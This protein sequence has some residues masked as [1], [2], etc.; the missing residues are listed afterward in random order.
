MIVAVVT[1]ESVAI[2]FASSA[3]DRRL[4]CAKG[5]IATKFA[6]CASGGL[7]CRAG[8]SA[9]GRVQQRRDRRRLRSSR[10][11][12]SRRARSTDAGRRWRS[13]AGALAERARPRSVEEIDVMRA[14]PLAA[15][16]N[17]RAHDAR[18]PRHHHDSGG[19]NIGSRPRFGMR[20]HDHVRRE[21]LRD[22][23]Q[24][25]DLRRERA[26]RRVAQHVVAA[27]VHQHEVVARLDPPR[28]AA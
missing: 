15:A 19:K 22:A 24:R 25:V 2:A 27:D 3:I 23:Q 14:V 21:L 9:R 16:A 12:R 18:P 5:D 7:D 20:R 1:R 26:Q 4:C 6:A 17:S 28:R 11:T 10:R 8:R 13:S